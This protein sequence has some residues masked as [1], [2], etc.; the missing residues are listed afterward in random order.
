MR[1]DTGG[2]GRGGRFGVLAVMSLALAGCGSWGDRIACGEDDCGWT[3]DAWAR[4]A[5]LAN[6]TATPPPRDSTNEYL[7]TDEVWLA[8]HAFDADATFDDPSFEIPPIVKLGWELYYDPRL[9]GPAR[10]VD[11]LDR[12]TTTNRAPAR[13]CAMNVSCATCHDPARAGS[14]ATSIPRDV[15][16]GAGRYDVNA[17]QTLNVARYSLLY[18]NG[19]ADSVWAQAA[20]VIESSISMNGDRRNTARVIVENYAAEYAALF[21]EPLPSAADLARAETPADDCFKKV[22]DPVLMDAITR[23]HVNAAKAIA[24]Y[25]WMLSSDRSPF[26]LFVSEGPGSTLLSPA[27]QRGLKVFVGRGSCYDCHRTSLFSDGKLHNVGVPQAGESIPT[28]AECVV[29]PGSLQSTPGCAAAPSCDCV[30]RLDRPPGKCLPWG[31]FTGREKLGA[32]KPMDANFWRGSKYSGDPTSV[33]N[34]AAIPAPKGAWRTPSLRDVALT[35]PYMHDGLFETL[36]D[37]VWHYDQGGTAPRDPYG[38]G[39]DPASEASCTEIGPLGLSSQDRSDL[40]AFLGSLTGQA[41]PKRLTMPPPDA[42]V[43][44]S[45]PAPSCA[46]ASVVPVASASFSVGHP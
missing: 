38:A 20:Q 15:S 4:V 36:A 37:V 35:G 43:R 17:Q 2:A 31:A 10:L 41:R 32:Y 33:L 13:G 42:P 44:P 40:V 27:E 6:I 39:C 29:A 34:L 12:D 46:A 45:D 3:H 28:V 9:S 7:P 14:D 11:S 19:R 24:A 22:V 21:P 25:E 18:W 8:A 1:K 5:D 16:T 30:D 26:D 23:V